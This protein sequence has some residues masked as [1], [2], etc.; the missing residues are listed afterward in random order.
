MVQRV[1]DKIG[2][3]MQRRIDLDPLGLEQWTQLAKSLFDSARDF[4][5]IGPV[6][7]RH[8][9]HQ[10]R[11]TH[12]KRLAKGWYGGIGDIG[13]VGQPQRSSSA[14]RHHGL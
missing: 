12:D 5:R 13:D 9:D 4:K 14:R 10:A 2:G 6:L 3:A 11:S 1:F 7:A 8:R